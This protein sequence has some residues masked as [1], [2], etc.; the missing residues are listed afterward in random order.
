MPIGQHGSSP[1]MVS[2]EEDCPD[3]SDAPGVG[4][5]GR[6]SEAASPVARGAPQ[7]LHTTKQDRD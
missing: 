4:Q 3:S 6:L 5:R 7:R 2:F 1:K